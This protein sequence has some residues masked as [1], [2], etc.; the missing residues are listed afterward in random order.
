MT[1][2]RYLFGAGA[3]DF[4]IAPPSRHGGFV[5]AATD[6][7]NGTF[8]SDRTGGTQYTDLQTVNGGTMPFVRTDKEGSITPF[9]GPEGIYDGWLD[10]GGGDRVY[11]IGAGIVVDAADATILAQA[12]A[13]SAQ[14]S[15]NSAAAARTA[16]QS[17]AADAVAGAQSK[18]DASASSAAASAASS[19][20]SATSAQNAA[21]LVGAPAGNAIDTYVGGNNSVVATRQGV[22]M[23]A[24]IDHA[25]VQAALTSAVSGNNRVVAG[26]SYSTDQTLIIGADCDLGALNINYTGT[27]VAVQVGDSSLGHLHRK[28]IA[29]PKVTCGTK[30]AGASWSAGTVGV[31]VVNTFRTR[32]DVP[33][34]KNFE[35]GLLLYGDGSYGLGGTSY[36]T[37]NI[38][39][40]ENNFVNQK[41]DQTAPGITSPNAPE[42][43]W[44]TQCT[45]VGGSW[46]HAASG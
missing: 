36:C 5:V 24:T 29:L 4:A 28:R 37:F 17:A 21:N 22:I 6:V 9:Y 38:T 46:S 33:L 35:T 34:I 12:S 45:F 40:L 16:A 41:H 27:G 13:D 44:V 30:P 15:A 23:P 20:S 42:G 1:S 43:G 19:A 7:G 11:V 32:F 25:G 10:F 18:I 39:S 3:G 8:W 31:K 14:A 26:G 2:P